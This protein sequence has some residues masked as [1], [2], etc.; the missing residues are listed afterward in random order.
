MTYRKSLLYNV[1]VMLAVIVVPTHCIKSVIAHKAANHFSNNTGAPVY[2]PHP[3]RILC[4]FCTGEYDG[5]TPPLIRGGVCKVFMDLFSG[6]NRISGDI[7]FMP[8]LVDQ[9]KKYAGCNKLV[10]GINSKADPA[11]IMVKKILLVFISANIICQSMTVKDASD[12]KEVGEDAQVVTKTILR[13]SHR[14]GSTGIQT[15]A[16]FDD[17][18]WHR[19]KLACPIIE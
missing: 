7:T 14:E 18:Y 1:E 2:L 4:S 15:Y 6:N 10:F 12:G 19:I 5:I 17:Y 16:M 11:P 9:I 3:C 13:Y 8:V